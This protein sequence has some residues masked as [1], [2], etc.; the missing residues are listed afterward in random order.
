M[1]VITLLWNVCGPG[2][3]WGKGMAGIDVSDVNFGFTQRNF[4]C[5]HYYYSVTSRHLL[6]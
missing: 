4:I 6:Q 1:G 2:S 5:K 3:S